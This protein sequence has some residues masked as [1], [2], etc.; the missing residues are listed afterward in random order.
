MIELRLSD[1]VRAAVTAGRPVVALESAV[2]THG[3]PFPVNLETARRLEAS[4]R[5]AGA[6]PATVGLIAGLPHVGLS[7][8]QIERLAAGAQRPSSLSAPAGMTPPPPMKVS[9]RDLG[10]AAVERL[11]GGTTV[12]ATAFLAHRAGLRVFATGGIGGVHR[13]QPFD[14]SADL[15][16]LATTPLLVVSAGAKSLLDLPLTLEWLE[17]HGVPV[18]GYQTGDFP[19]F[20]SRRSG[21]RLEARVDT[22]AAAAAL[23]QAHWDL[24][25]TSAVLLVVP[26]PLA[27]ELPADEME[28]AIAAA[29]AD[30][31]RAGITGKDLTPFILARV[32]ALTGK[33]SLEAN[34]ALLNQNA[35]IAAEVAQE[36]V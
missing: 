13:G 29:I 4:V 34:L 18:V 16:V 19:A 32:S 24:G 11:D 5:Q 2:I 14:I 22:P 10:R 6:V 31:E 35:R 9:L 17:T 1:E 30:A 33:R 28:A 12:A 36:M 3:L 20:Y 7:D 26:V 8:T 25:L 23:A 27:A 15:P 21:L